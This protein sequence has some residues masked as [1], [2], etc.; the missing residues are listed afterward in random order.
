MSQPPAARK[1]LLYRLHK[2]Q[3]RRAV[4]AAQRK[5]SVLLFQ[6]GKLLLQRFNLCVLFGKCGVPFLKQYIFFLLRLLFLFFRLS[7]R[8]LHLLPQFIQVLRGKQGQSC[9]LFAFLTLN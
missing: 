6:L 8:F 3:L 4:P 7:F 2:Q 5:N 9:F 1:L